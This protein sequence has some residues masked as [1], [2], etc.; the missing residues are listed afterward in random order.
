[1]KTIGL[2][3][4]TGWVSSVDYYRII[5]LE[6]NK[7]QGGLTFAKCILYSVNYGEIDAF[8]KRNDLE[9]VYTLI[10]DAANK[11]VGIGADCILLCANTLHMFA[12]R[13]EQQIPV[14]LIHI[15][16]ATAKHIKTRNI[17]K[18]GLLGTRDTMEKDFYKSKLNKE[19][20]QVFV[21]EK[22]DREFIHNTIMNEI[23]KEILSK[24][25]KARFLEIINNLQLKGAEGIV[26]G[27]TEIPLLIK[28]TDVCIPVF[29]TTVIHSLAAVDFALGKN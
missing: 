28:E 1:M 17:T 10:L 11:L 21:P 15:A 20:I 24:T 19:N 14:P 26:L 2:V 4:G 23:L 29:N 12:D 7:R 9:G 8:N 25:S 3:G 22:N 16:T 27:C 5:N 18:V 13:I 6:I